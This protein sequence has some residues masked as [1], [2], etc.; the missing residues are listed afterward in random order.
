MHRTIDPMKEVAVTVGASQVGREGGWER[1]SEGGREGGVTL[2][3]FS[4]WPASGREIL[5]AHAQNHRCNE[6]S[7]GHSE[8]FAGKEGGRTGVRE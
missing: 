4:F 3:L 5:K 7:S 2:L 6:R 1:G 8:C